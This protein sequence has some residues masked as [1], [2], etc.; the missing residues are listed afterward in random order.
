[1]GAPEGGRTPQPVLLQSRPSAPEAPRGGETGATKTARD[2]RLF[3]WRDT[4]DIYVPISKTAHAMNLTLA[5]FIEECVR[6]SLASS[7]APKSALR[8]RSNPA[9]SQGV[10]VSLTRHALDC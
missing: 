3:Q 1:V 8:T 4:L 2:Q 6:K 7:N 5:A 9:H 10:S